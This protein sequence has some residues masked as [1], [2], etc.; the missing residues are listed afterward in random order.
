MYADSN[1]FNKIY[2]EYYRKS[3]LFVKSYVHDDFIAKDLVSEAMIKLWKRMNQEPVDQIQPYLFTILKNSALDYLK[4]EAIKN[5]V[6]H[7][8]TERL[9]RELDIRISILQS[10][11]PNEIFSSE[12]QE[13]VRNTLISLPEKTRRAFEMSRYL[14]KPNKEIA[15]VLGVTVKG[16]DYHMSVAIRE[17]RIALK[18]YLSLLICF[19]HFF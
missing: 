10:T 17:L 12:I 18:D 16:V 9:N 3:F 1:S 5:T 14:D 7:A 6:H 2:T 15:E 19:F 4:H 11:D 13:I 8:I